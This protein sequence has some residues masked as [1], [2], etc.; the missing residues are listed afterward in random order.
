MVLFYDEPTRSLDPISAQKIRSWIIE[1]RKR[2]PHQTHVIATNH[3]YEAEQLCDGVVIIGQGRLL[4]HGTIEDIR[5]RG[6]VRDGENHLV[7]VRDCPARLQLQADPSIG[8]LEVHAERGAE[9]TTLRVRTARNCSALTSVLAHIIDAGG[10]VV[11]C[12]TDR[13]SFDEVFLDL[14]NEGATAVAPVRA[15]GRR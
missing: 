14:V 3:L 8:L 2:H 12:E 1:R 4:A 5:S 13:E 15:G 6:Q 11:R 9:T 7:V 10:V